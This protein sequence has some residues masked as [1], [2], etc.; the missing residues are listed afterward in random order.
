MKLI[1]QICL[2]SKVKAEYS[3]LYFLVAN[4]LSIKHRHVY[5]LREDK[6]LRDVTPCSLVDV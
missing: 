3:F 4:P 5:I 6:R 1:F 2:V